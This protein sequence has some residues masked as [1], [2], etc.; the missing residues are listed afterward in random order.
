MAGEATEKPEEVLATTGAATAKPEED[1]ISFSE[2][3]ESRPPSQ[4]LTKIKDMLTVRTSDAGP[5]PAIIVTLSTPDLQLHCSSDPCNGLRFFR[6]H[7]GDKNIRGSVKTYLTYLCSNCQTQTKIFSLYARVAKIG[8]SSTTGHCLKFGEMPAF[9]PMTPSRLLKLF[10]GDRE[11]FLK[12]RQCENHDLGVGAFVYY[13]RVVENHKD[14]IIGEII[15]VCEK[16]KAP[17][18]MIGLLQAAKKENQFSKAVESIKDAIPESLRIDGHNP[19]TLLYKALS[20]GVHDKTDEE[21][22]ELARD[23][24]LVLAELSERLASAL[25]NEDELKTAVSRLLKA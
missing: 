5:S 10:D 1:P 3:L 20:E 24:R 7:S 18:D 23:I 11:L 22:L 14:R 19:L 9:G 16:V 25:K 2:F 12:G 15:K 17:A 8:K 4:R 13:R 6:Y 21:C